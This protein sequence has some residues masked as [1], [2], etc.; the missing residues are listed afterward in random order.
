MEVHSLLETLM[1]MERLIWLSP[2]LVSLSILILVVVWKSSFLLSLNLFLLLPLFFVFCC[3]CTCLFCLL[4]LL[5]IYFVVFYFVVCMYVL[6]FNFL[7]FLK[8]LLLHYDTLIRSEEP[9]INKRSIQNKNEFPKSGSILAVGKKRANFDSPLRRIFE[10]K[11]GNF[12][13]WK[14]V[15]CR[16]W[17]QWWFLPVQISTKKKKKNSKNHKKDK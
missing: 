17:C 9:I 5:C 3:F 1:E 11:F 4:L 10:S 8:Y 15:N 7:L 16:H 14:V 6:N 2:L 12:A 13:F